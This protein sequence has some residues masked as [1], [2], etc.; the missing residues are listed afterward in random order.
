VP[1]IAAGVGVLAAGAVVAYLSMRPASPPP[2]TAPTPSA[3]APTPRPAL[4][5]APVREA[6]PPRRTARPAA[7]SAPEPAAPV[8][9]RAPTT[10]TLHVE[11]DVPEAKV[12]VDRVSRGTT[13][14]TLT[15][16]PPGP[17]R[18]NITAPGY[19]GYSEDVD[20][21]PGERT[22]SVSF[23]Q[24]RL[25]T[26][27]DVTHK[28]GM[29]SCKGRLSATPQGI[30]FD[31]ADGKDTFSLPLIDIATLE[32]DYLEKNLRLRTRSGKTY[33]FTDSNADRLF[34]FHED[35]NKARKLMATP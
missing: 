35:V 32:V 4:P 20:L 25:D 16:L 22:I 7:P 3:T 18:I 8:A 21:V 9:E 13:P 14:L 30:R 33:N 28:H 31:A 19:D 5:E 24:V 27:L 6:P 10:S 29:G 17:H 23:K 12:F 34:A 26:V 2:A 1:L 11:A 15:D